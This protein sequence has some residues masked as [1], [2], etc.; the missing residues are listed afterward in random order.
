MKLKFE[1]ADMR[2]FQIEDRTNPRKSTLYNNSLDNEVIMFK[3]T[4]SNFLSMK[5]IKIN[6]MWI[7]Q[8]I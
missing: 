5:T 4:Y 3:N 8:I 7:L 6:F 1:M 2:D